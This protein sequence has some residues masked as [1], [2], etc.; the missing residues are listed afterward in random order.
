MDQK[1]WH[2]Q[3]NNQQIGP[4]DKEEILQLLA[5]QVL[6]PDTL[7]WSAGM[8]NWQPMRQVPELMATA[9]EPVKQRPT[10]VTVL[11]ILNIVFGGLGILCSPFAV[12]SLLIPQPT[13]S[14]FEI[15][16]AMKLFSMFSYGLGFVM[17]II[18]LAS[19][20][21]LLNLKKWARQTAYF[22]GWFTVAWG[23]LS[24]VI[25]AVLFSTGAAIS[26]EAT[27]EM[28]GGIIG[29]IIG[30]MCGGLIGMIY[31]VVLIVLLRKPHVVQVCS[32]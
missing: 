31:P 12:I 6:T 26:S 9:S 16:Y 32:K 2:Y 18:L 11:A 13:G 19:G 10:S 22:Y 5:Q 21:G 14:G 24:I 3:L 20:I 4:V 8:E 23:I 30:G 15:S 25:N 7:I 27:P 28:A 29:G 17:S 1:D